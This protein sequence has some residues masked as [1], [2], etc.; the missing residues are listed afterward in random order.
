[1]AKPVKH[2]VTPTVQND[3]TNPVGAPT[4]TVDWDTVDRGGSN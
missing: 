2:P 1:M 3:R 4:D